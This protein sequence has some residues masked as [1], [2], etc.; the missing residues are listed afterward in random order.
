MHL[1]PTSR[2]KQSQTS[3]H[4]GECMASII[5][6]EN[7]IKELSRGYQKFVIQSN[8]DIWQASQRE[9]FLCVHELSFGV[10]TILNEIDVRTILPRYEVPMTTK[11]SHGEV[12]IFIMGIILSYVLALYID[13]S[14][15]KNKN[16]TKHPYPTNIKNCEILIVVTRMVSKK[17]IPYQYW[18]NPGCHILTGGDILDSKGVSNCRL[19]YTK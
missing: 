8:I 3:M 7:G 19:P 1:L 6:I 17:M 12:S 13:T 10:N 5:N 2:S 11:I 18:L 16:A 9:I 15:I 14:S 4:I